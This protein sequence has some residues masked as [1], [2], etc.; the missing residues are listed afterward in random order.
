MASHCPL[1]NL[2]ILVYYVQRDGWLGEK[3][4]VCV[5]SGIQFETGVPTLYLKAAGLSAI[6]LVVGKALLI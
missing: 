6:P 1:T 2:N 4:N 5:R 3:R